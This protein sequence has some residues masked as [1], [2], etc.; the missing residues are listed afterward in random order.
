MVGSLGTW[1]APAVTIRSTPVSPFSR[2]SFSSRAALSSGKPLVGPY[3]Q[4]G[5]VGKACM[6]IIIF[7]GGMDVLCGR[8]V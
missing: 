2:S 7:C 3:L 1:F 6:V 5:A 8:H 4:A